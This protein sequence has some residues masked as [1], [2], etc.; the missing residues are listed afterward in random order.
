[1]AFPLHPPHPPQSHA[2]REVTQLASYLVELSLVDYASLKF[3]YSM[4]AASAVYV[5]QLSAGASDPFCHTLS[6][7]CGYTLAAIQDC[8]THLAGLMR[9]VRVWA[10]PGLWIGVGAECTAKTSPRPPPLCTL[11]SPVKAPVPVAPPNTDTT[12]LCRLQASNSSLVAVHKKVSGLLGGWPR[13]PGGVIVGGLV[14]RSPHPTLCSS[15]HPLAAPPPRLSP[16]L[17]FSGDKHGNVAATFE[18][19]ALLLA[20]VQL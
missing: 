11:P 4:I 6:R 14:Q 10:G 8:S 9:K 16:P 15:S 7:H 3:P 2:C 1:M 12:L 13:L 5:A 20:P 18:A 19:P 17:Q